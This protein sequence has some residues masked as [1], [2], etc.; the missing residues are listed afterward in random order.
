MDYCLLQF[1]TL[2]VFLGA[3]HHGVGNSPIRS[4]I[5]TLNPI[6]KL[7]VIMQELYLTLISSMKTLKF[8]NE[9]VN[10]TTEITWIQT[11]T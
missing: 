1:D 5:P 9:I 6:N 3:R 11:F 2:N 7:T 10:F 4:C 8:D